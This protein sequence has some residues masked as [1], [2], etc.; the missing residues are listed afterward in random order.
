MKVGIVNPISESCRF[1]ATRLL[2]QGTE[3]AFLCLDDLDVNLA[4]HMILELAVLGKV[5]DIL[6]S[7]QKSFSVVNADLSDCKKQTYFKI[8]RFISIVSKPIKIF[9]VVVAFV[10]ELSRIIRGWTN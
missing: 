8:T 6:H 9:F 3:V 2:D 5:N 4:Q 10:L 7:R 1:L